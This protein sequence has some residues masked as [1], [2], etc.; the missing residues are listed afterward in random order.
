MHKTPKKMPSR[1]ERG[2]PPRL[3][4]KN[5]VSTDKVE[6]LISQGNNAFEKGQ[7]QTASKL[8]A[9]AIEYSPRD[10]TAL[11]NLGAALFN[12]GEIGKAKSVIQYALELAP[13]NFESLVNL[14]SILL[15]EHKY[16][17]ALKIS[18]T[19]ASIN[20]DSALA[21]NNI[22]CCFSHLNLHEHALCSYETASMLDPN[23]FESKLNVALSLGELDRLDEAALIYENLI[24]NSNIIE[25][26]L[27]NAAKF[28][29][30]FNLLSRGILDPGWRYY[31]FGFDCKAMGKNARTPNRIFDIPK[32]N[33]DLN[34]RGKLLVWRE[35][36]IGDEIWFASCLPDLVNTNLDVT[37][38]CS[39]RLLSSFKRSFPSITVRSEKMPDTTSELN[40]D[41]DFHIPIGS[42]PGIFR[43]TNE[44]FSRAQ[45]Y[46]NACEQFEYD[47]SKRLAQF[48]HNKLI[49]ISWRST[50][51]DSSRNRHYTHLS[52]W[53]EIINL[54]GCTFVNLQYG[55]CESEILELEALT[56]KEILRWKDIDLKNDL[57][58][59]FSL[60]KCLDYVISV[61]NA[62]MMMAGASGTPSIFISRSNG[63]SLLG[64]KNGKYPWFKNTYTVEFPLDK[65]ACDAL[66][67]VKYLLETILK[68]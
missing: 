32:W 9:E 7:F 25:N 36:G 6:N 50:T 41:F 5:L 38:E 62:V 48:R 52:D 59:V 16:D 27:K 65:T 1:M 66:P 42:L 26:D 22:G 19:A 12:L 64:A 61:D 57:D 35:Q 13:N 43:K 30:S 11:S 34:A 68:V 17:E 3:D 51:L 47:F 29:Y 63:W 18:L 28:F 10:A 33:G 24:N 49:G 8:Y 60:I 21:H 15:K 56:G 4:S 46:I 23:Y 2:R 39:P 40:S 31:E 58:R 45:P 44:S 53:F 20:P 37:L 54:D 14:G 55:P 67:Q